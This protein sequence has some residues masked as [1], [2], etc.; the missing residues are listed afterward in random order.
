MG[1][2]AI[3]LAFD[4]LLVAVSAVPGLMPQF[5]DSNQKA[6]SL[7]ASI[8]NQLGNINQLL[9][10]VK[11]SINGAEQSLA[12]KAALKELDELSNGLLAA[13]QVGLITTVQRDSIHE[14]AIEITE[15]ISDYN[16]PEYA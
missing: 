1:E 6:A 12:L 3:M 2:D 9:S 10:S 7:V 14:I 5:V 15:H 13:S 16:D 11:G 8:H 4:R